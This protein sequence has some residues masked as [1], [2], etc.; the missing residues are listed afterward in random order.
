MRRFLFLVVLVVSVAACGGSSGGGGGA[1]NGPAS[2]P[3]GAVNGFINTIKA[4]AFD[5]LPALVCAAQKDAILGGLTGGSNSAAQALMAAMS[6]DF[7][8][9][10]VTQSSVN[11]DN[12]VVHVTG[13]LVTTVDAGKAKD[14]AKQVLGGQATDDMINQMVAAMNTSRDVDQDVNVVKENGGWVVCSNIGQ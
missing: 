1:A 10:N 12:A 13:K 8:N 11:G 9:G 14:L 5:K 4:H 7:Q 3:V 2:D 6:F